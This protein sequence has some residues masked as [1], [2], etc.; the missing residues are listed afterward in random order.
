MDLDR[1]CVYNPLG[2]NIEKLAPEEGYVK[3]GKHGFIRINIFSDVMVKINLEWSYD[4]IHK[5]VVSAFRSG[6]GIWRSERIECMMPYVRVRI[7]NESGHA[8][9]ELILHFFTKYGARRESIC[10][11]P[12]PTPALP[13][14]LKIEEVKEIK[15]EKKRTFMFLKKDKAPPS[16]KHDIFPGY[17][18]KGCILIGGEK[19]KVSVLPKGNVGEYLMMTEQGP[20]WCLP[21]PPRLSKK[22]QETLEANEWMKE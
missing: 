3:V 16:P 11:N 22:E 21:F 12:T 19:G 4:G 15:D 7:I 1:I 20:S 9:N 6:S 2:E 13:P 14:P 10:N 5:G 8:N 18:P 17:I